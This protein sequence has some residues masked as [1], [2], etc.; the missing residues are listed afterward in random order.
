MLEMPEPI[1]LVAVDTETSGLHPDPPENARLSVISLAYR[2]EPDEGSDAPAIAS[3]AYAFD[4]GLGRGAQATLSLDVDPNLD[5][6]AF[7][8]LLE[9]LG[10]YRLSFHGG[11]F[12]LT[13]LLVGTSTS[14]GMDLSGAIAWDTMLA[15]RDLD[16]MQDA[17]LEDVERRMDYLSAPDRAAWLA[18]KAQRGGVNRMD[19]NTAAEYA[20]LDA[21][22]T[23]VAT[24]WQL[25][26]YGAGEGQRSALDTELA[27]TRALF[28]LERRGIGFDATTA[29]VAGKAM[30]RRESQIAM[31]LPFKPAT[32]NGAKKY[33]FGV[34]GYEPRTTTKKGAPQLDDQEVAR[35]V[36]LGAP[37]APEYQRL[38]EI[39]HARTSWY[40]AYADKTGWDGRL[41]TVYSQAQVV[42]GRLSS[43]RVN[44][45]AIPHDYQLATLVAEGWPTPRSLFL[46]AKGKRLWELD[47]SQAELRVAAV[48]AGCDSMLQ[49]IRDGADLHGVVTTQLFN[50]TPDD[51]AWT[52]RRQVGKRA[53][54]SFIFGVGAETF[55]RDLA[56]QTGIWLPLGECNAIVQRW[57]RL[58]PEYG[59]AINTYMDA[60]NHHGY[61]RLVNGRVRYFRS[62]EDR[63]KAFNQYV[64]G[65]L[66]QLMDAWLL[67][68]EAAI[69]G[70][71]LLTIHDSLVLETDDPG[72]VAVIRSMGEK[73]GTEMFGVPMV[74]DLKGWRA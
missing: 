58:Y 23:L 21:E 17:G 42:S 53:D 12:D 49:L 67:Q 37:G 54:F 71:I 60:A 10:A 72:L 57:R 35:L 19:W 66:A 56:K 1:G 25:D 38:Q 9:W 29:R 28:R 73:L 40:E 27:K 50:V 7:V 51:D 14:A 55:Q 59:R 74:V 46:P 22:I 26:R 47:L 68:A 48:E 16:P 36:A 61:V 43:T 69:P 3:A 15:S 41:R 70:V 11:K 2:C 34:C 24:E 45:Q 5:A 62:Y 32:V 63:H 13:H 6:D 44:L 20:R 39:K 4:W 18:A 30:A 31:E 8:R 52:E 64:Q 65:S 33:W